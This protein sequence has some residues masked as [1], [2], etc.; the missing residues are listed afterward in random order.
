M[1]DI[2]R[3]AW[4]GAILLAAACGGGRPAVPA[5]GPATPVPPPGPSGDA[6]GRPIDNGV[7]LATF[8][9]AWERIAH[10]HYDTTFRGVDWDSVREALR[11][12]AAEASTHEQL[13][14]VIREMLARLGESHYSVIPGE[15]AGAVES[16]AREDGGAGDIG[17][18]LRIADSAVVVARIDPGGPA[19]AAGVRLG[20]IVDAI[21]DRILGE[22]I[23]RLAELE[24]TSG[25]R[26][27]LT[28]FL[29]SVTG[30]L[31]GSPG[32]NVRLSVRPGDDRTRSI[33]LVRRTRP[34]QPVSFGNLPMLVADLDYRVLPAGERC[35]GVIRF[36]VW[37]TAIAPSFDRAVDAVRD[38][39]GVII[40]LRGNPGGVAGMVMGVAG[41]FMNERRPLGV[42]KTRSG[43]LRLVANPRTVNSGGQTVEPYSGP[44]ALLIDAL[45]VSTSE[46][47]AAGLQAAGRARVFGQTSAGQALPAMAI[48]LPNGDVLMHVVADLTVPDG[49]RVEGEGVAPDVL[50][51]LSRQ[52]LL[53]GRDAVLE[54]ALDWIL[55]TGSPPE[56]R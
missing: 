12:R 13:R 28:Q 14:D 16:G 7:A 2:R 45:T 39:Q 26:L 15:L 17:I 50:V 27:A 48:R 47:F 5:P 31:E 46:I 10:T 55:S 4:M 22:E 21:D 8:D 32:S 53:E 6:R 19:A 36:N 38:C 49:R 43:E 25:Y 3:A 35:V 34:G 37:M 51:P 30:A 52:D 23:R 33:E 40:D 29:W 54:S 11:P 9:S 44:V 56:N 24:G 1:F 42:L 41:H 20:W 18:D